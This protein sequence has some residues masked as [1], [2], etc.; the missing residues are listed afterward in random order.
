M[1][2]QQ[3]AAS[4]CDLIAAEPTTWDRFERI[5]TLVNNAFYFGTDPEVLLQEIQE[6]LDKIAETLR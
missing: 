4:G 2:E 3:K 5:G 6:Q 1:A